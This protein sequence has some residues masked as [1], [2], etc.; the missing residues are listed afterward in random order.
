VVL[1]PETMEIVNIF[2]IDHDKC[3]GPQGM[4]V[5]PE[6]QILLGC[7]AS[8]SSVIINE[9]SGAA[10][11]VLQSEGGPDQV[12][13][14]MPAR[15]TPTP[16]PPAPG[17]RATGWNQPYV[18]A[19]GRYTYVQQWVP[20]PLEQWVAPADAEADLLRSALLALEN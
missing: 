18:D 2:N 9:H 3:A 16:R 1:S 14:T 6:N 5:G 13:F 10:I 11:R 4:A 17:S 15:T 19:W 12:G 20:A 7:N 8:S